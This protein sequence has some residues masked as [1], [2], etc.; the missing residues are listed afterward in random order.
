MKVREGFLLRV[1]G[2]EPVVVAVG[3]ASKYFNGMI[4]LNASG[5]F[6]FELMKED[7]SKETLVDKLIEKYDV[8][9]EKADKD[10][11]AFIKT[12]KGAKVLDD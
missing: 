11:D 12:L 6:L 7:V 5:V 10:V 8:D 1:I 4:K 9:R 2:D 3:G